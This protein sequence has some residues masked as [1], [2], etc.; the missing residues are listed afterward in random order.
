MKN[1]KRRIYM[2]NGIIIISIVMILEMIFL[3][4]V[5]SYYLGSVRQEMLN[6]ANIS[7]SFYNK[8]LVNEP[9]REK[10][11]YIL[12][13]ES[14]N[15][16][17]FFQVIDKDKRILTDSY[18]VSNGKS[19]LTSDVD[20]ALNGSMEVWTDRN[21]ESGEFIMSVS[22]PLYHFKEVKGVLRYVTSLEEVEKTI[23]RISFFSVF[24]GLV[25]IIFS[26]GFS[27]FLA[28]QIADPIKDLTGIAEV[29]AAGDFSKRALKR[30]DDEI[31]RLADTLNYLAEEIVRSD[32]IKNEFISSISHELRTPLTAIRGWSETLLTGTMTDTEEMKE[33]LTIISVETE[34]LT[35]LVEELL[36]FSRLQS[37]RIQLH[38]EALDI[39][40][41]INEVSEQFKIRLEE[42]RIQMVL[43]LDDNHR[44]LAGDKNRLKQ[45]LINIIDNAIK[46]SKHGDIIEV[47]TIFEETFV[48]IRVKDYGAGISPE[49][50]R[51]ITEKFY[52]GKSIHSGS[53][54][55]LAICKEIVQ[56][57][58]GI[59]HIKS[60]EGKGTTVFIS[61]PLE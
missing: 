50:V 37:G 31:G 23:R 12:E 53:G 32:K 18:G 4:S 61:L 34:R 55:G 30:N 6:K 52:K 22:L 57:H 29:M 20:I 11:R 43:Y 26:F 28:R 3:F 36:D 8:Y 41:L 2:Q 58:K 19:F 45:V 38:I 33:G 42:K 27:S 5:K 1:I 56:L 48:C 10:A 60:G 13:N 35:G 21:A 16:V 51:H 25:V 46:F 7:G 59:L 24:I 39:H 15:P 44:S 40:Q 47:S 49:D 17:I 14:R 9:M 54:L